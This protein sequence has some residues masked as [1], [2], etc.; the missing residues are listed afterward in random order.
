MATVGDLSHRSWSPA[1][2]GPPG[3]SAA[4]YVAVD[5][6]PDQVWLPWMVRFAASGS[7]VAS[8]KT[9]AAATNRPIYI[10]TGEFE[11]TIKLFRNN[12]M[13][14]YCNSESSLAAKTIFSSYSFANRDLGHN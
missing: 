5:G 13:H 12:A 2:T 9:V 3:P 8:R 14:V 10:L 11:V 1:T 7:P 6:P 4:S